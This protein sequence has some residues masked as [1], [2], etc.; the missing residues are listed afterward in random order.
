VVYFADTS[1]VTVVDLTVD[2]PRAI[3]DVFGFAKPQGMCVSEDGRR[4]RRQ[5]RPDSSGQHSI[6]VVAV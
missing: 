2:P 1:T 4:L 5:R 6:S 3:E